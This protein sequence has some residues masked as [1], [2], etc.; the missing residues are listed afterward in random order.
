MTTEEL[1][2]PE[3]DAL[4]HARVFG[5]ETGGR[6]PPFSTR[7]WTALA[8]AELVS[9]RT[10]WKYQLL[11][12][13]KGWTAIWFEPHARRGSL[14]ALVSSRAPTRALAL[15]RA[16]LKAVGSPR[17]PEARR[18]HEAGFADGQGPERASG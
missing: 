9:D 14:S 17:W 10:G 13:G 16:L 15:C 1:A 8:L 4:L 7:D 3:L 12:Q 5:G 6:V 11:E 18:F 2:G